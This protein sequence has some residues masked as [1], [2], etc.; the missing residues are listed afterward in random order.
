MLLPLLLAMVALMATACGDRRSTDSQ[1]IP[2][3]PTAPSPASAPIGERWNT[4]TTLRGFT[5]PEPCSAVYSPYIGQSNSWWMV[6]ERSGEALHI[7][8]S[9][10]DESN[11]R[12]E[13]NGTVVSNVLTAIS[14]DSAEGRV[15]GGARVAVRAERRLSGRFSADGHALT[16]EEVSSSQLSSGETLTFYS[17]LTATQQ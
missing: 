12:I 6:V 7:V 13:Y 8:V 2:S 11:E 9:D 1:S 14:R 17:D 15:C 4:T 3:A 10:P 5:G 16:A